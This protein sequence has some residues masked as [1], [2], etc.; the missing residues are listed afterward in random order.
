M[1]I[2][3]KP[4]NKIVKQNANERKCEAKTNKNKEKP[5]THGQYIFVFEQSAQAYTHISKPST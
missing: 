4:N 5:T 3:H 1:T 2:K